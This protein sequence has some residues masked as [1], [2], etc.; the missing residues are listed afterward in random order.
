[1]SEVVQCSHESQSQHQVNQR[2]PTRKHQTQGCGH[3]AIGLRGALPAC[4]NTEHFA[5]NW[6]S[7]AQSSR[8]TLKTCIDSGESS[9]S[10]RAE[11]SEQ[12]LSPW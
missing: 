4:E 10:F 12:G 2:G 3:K 1:M 11:G 7:A 9:C 8:V 5:G 6:S